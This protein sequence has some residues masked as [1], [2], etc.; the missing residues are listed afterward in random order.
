[1]TYSKGSAL[2]LDRLFSIAF[3]AHVTVNTDT[4]P[5]LVEATVSWR[6]HPPLPPL[7]PLS[8]KCKAL[9]FPFYLVSFVRFSAYNGVNVCDIIFV[10]SVLRYRFLSCDFNAH[11]T[12][13][14]KDTSPEIFEATVFWAYHPLPCTSPPETSTVIVMLPSLA[15]LCASL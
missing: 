3:A 1:M 12:A 10:S 11:A 5:N 14:Y 9:R 7:D 13:D 2:F 4:P 6:F 15:V 8:V